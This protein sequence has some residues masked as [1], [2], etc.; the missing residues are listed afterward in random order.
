MMFFQNI[1]NLFSSDIESLENVVQRKI[2]IVRTEVMPWQ[3]LLLQKPRELDI[4][5]TLYTIRR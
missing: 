1:D 5:H 4:W 2:E 3:D